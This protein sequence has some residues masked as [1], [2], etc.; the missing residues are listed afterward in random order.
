[1]TAVTVAFDEARLQR[2]H[3]AADRLGLSVEEL[4]RL[5]VDEYLERRQEA[6]R[7]AAEYVLT[8][9]AELYRRLAR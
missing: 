8:K 5:S 6:V 9:N 3:Q 4:V 7:E 1:M 2:L